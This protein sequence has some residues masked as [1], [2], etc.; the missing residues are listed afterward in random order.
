MELSEFDFDLPPELIAQRPL[1]ERDAFADA[2]VSTGLSDTMQD[3]QFREFPEML[4]GDEL[5]VSQQ[6]T[7]AACAAVW[8]A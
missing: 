7:S 6:C 5:I 8:T 4:R 3:R 2:R 1:E